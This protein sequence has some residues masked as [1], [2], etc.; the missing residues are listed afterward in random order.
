MKKFLN[1]YDLLGFLFVCLLTSAFVLVPE[2]ASAQTAGQ[3]L[4]SDITNMLQGSIGTVVGLGVSL[5]GL[6]VWLAQQSSWGL[7]IVIA[8]AAITAFPGLY[9]GMTDGFKAAF[10]GSGAQGRSPN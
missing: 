10:S 8:G 7:L 1:E 3:G 5:F 2:V 4:L 9:K 6:W